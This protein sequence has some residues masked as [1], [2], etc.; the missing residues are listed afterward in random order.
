MSR[1]DTSDPT[2]GA[3]IMDTAFPP[4]ANNFYC[5][6]LGKK[7][8]G[9]LKT[10]P[11][12]QRK[13]ASTS[14]RTTSTI[15]RTTQLESEVQRLREQ[16]A[17]QA[18]YNATQAAYVAEIHASSRPSSSRCSSTCMTL[19]LPSFRDFRLRPCLRSCRYPSRR[20]LRNSPQKRILI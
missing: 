4:R 16:Q 14:S 11:G 18:A 17:A 2:I 13:A 8:E 9:V 12:F 3:R 10:I 19:Q 5:R 1:I 15:I 7:G 6:G 20:N